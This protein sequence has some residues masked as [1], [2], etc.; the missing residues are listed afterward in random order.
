MQRI[1]VQ[2]N[3]LQCNTEYGSKVNY[4]TLLTGLHNCIYLSHGSLI[5]KKMIRWAN[6]INYDKWC[7]LQKRII[8]YVTYHNYLGDHVWGFL[9]FLF[10]LFKAIQT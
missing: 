10:K 7:S 8:Y 3:A 9:C 2:Y 1:I 5:W 4:N 6:H